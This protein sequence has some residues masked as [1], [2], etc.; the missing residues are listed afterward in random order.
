[1]GGAQP[2]RDKVRKRASTGK[3]HPPPLS[4]VD[5]AFGYEINWQN[6]S[7]VFEA[8]REFKAPSYVYLIGEGE[9]GPVKIGFAKDPIKR[10]RAMQT[11]NSQRLRIEHMIVGDKQIEKLLHETWEPLAIISLRNVSRPD[12]PPGTEWFFPEIREELFPI[13]ESVA[14]VQIDMLKQGY[15]ISPEGT[16]SLLRGAHKQF[17]REK[18]SPI[19][20]VRRLARGSGYV[21]SKT[22]NKKGTPQRRRI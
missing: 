7:P 5:K 21:V 18:P 19:E 11:G 12:S 9:D 6:V 8:T 2:I 3:E 13:I 22:R 1:M 20:G 15:S 16:E 14:E 10:L 4:P 17:G